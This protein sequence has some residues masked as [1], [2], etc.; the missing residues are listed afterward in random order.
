M[1]VR[2]TGSSRLAYSLDEFVPVDL[3]I[4]KLCRPAPGWRQLYSAIHIIAGWILIPLLVAAVTGF[5][6]K[7]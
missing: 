1:A 6:G 7:R 4:A 5:L 3:Q 2:S